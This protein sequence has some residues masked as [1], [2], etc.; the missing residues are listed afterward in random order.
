MQA[1]LLLVKNLRQHFAERDYD[2]KRFTVEIQQGKDA[3]G[4]EAPLTSRIET[5]R[6]SGADG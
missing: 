1:R 4:A 6:E 3:Q 5:V 2:Y